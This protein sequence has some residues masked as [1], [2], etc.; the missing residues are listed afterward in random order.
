MNS[1]LTLTN[2]RHESC[3]PNDGCSDWSSLSSARRTGVDNARSLHGDAAQNV[4][5]PDI[6]GAAGCL[7]TGQGARND[8]VRRVNFRLRT[9]WL[10][11]IVYLEEYVMIF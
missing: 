3:K 7:R 10:T 5:V 9:L 8:F 1:K 2:S 11:D 4:T 6:T